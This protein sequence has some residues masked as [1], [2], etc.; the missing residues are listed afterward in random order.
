[1]AMFL[2][3]INT[4]SSISSY[5]NKIFKGNHHFL[6]KPTQILCKGPKCGFKTHSLFFAMQK[7]EKAKCMM[8]L[9]FLY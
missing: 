5:T 9:S 8:G 4:P 1:M 2:A 6:K 7:E 3:L